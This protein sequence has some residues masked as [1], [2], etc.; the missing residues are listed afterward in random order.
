MVEIPHQIKCTIQN[1]LW[2]KPSFHFYT[3]RLE[4]IAL[5]MRRRIMP[6]AFA[7]IVVLIS[8]CSVLKRKPPCPCPG[9]GHGQIDITEDKA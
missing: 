1:I 2:M 4:L 6:L 3:I 7:L 8:A 5:G 9:N